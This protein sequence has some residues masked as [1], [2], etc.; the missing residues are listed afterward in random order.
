[1]HV[2]AGVSLLLCL[3]RTPL[4]PLAE[5][6]RMKK[7]CLLVVLSL[8]VVVAIAQHAQALPPINAAFHEK[9]AALKDE[10]TAKL[11]AENNDK[12]NVCHIAGKGKK[13]KNAYGIA[14]GK[15]INKA[16]IA[17]I[18]EAAGDNLEKA[19]ADTKTYIL[20]GLTKAEA[21]KNAAGMSFGDIIK[22]GKLPE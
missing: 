8:F 19:T 22:S 16:G 11:G 5:V 1:M 13:E 20:E 9:Y 2:A 12:C 4:F 18:K 7:V 14:V 10:V 3:L 21:E 15:H 17:K 6:L